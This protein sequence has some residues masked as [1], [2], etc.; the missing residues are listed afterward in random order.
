MLTSKIVVINARSE[1]N[2]SYLKEEILV[3]L[4][5]VKSLMTYFLDLKIKPF[6]KEKTQNDTDNGLFSL[7]S[8]KSFV[9][10][11]LN[12]TPPTKVKRN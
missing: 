1:G 6:E 12:V 8:W 11:G 2:N 7:N 10:L 9:S 4:E 3:I 5:G